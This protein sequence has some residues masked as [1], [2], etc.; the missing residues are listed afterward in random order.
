[1]SSPVSKYAVLVLGV[2]EVGP[3][4]LE[5]REDMMGAGDY[6]AVPDHPRFGPDGQDG[7]DDQGGGDRHQDR[8]DRRTGS[9]FDLHVNFFFF[10]FKN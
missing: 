8:H 3:R 1:M 2:V 10:F 7:H 9:I 6:V 4:L 5:L